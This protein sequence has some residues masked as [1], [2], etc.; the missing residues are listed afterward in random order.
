MTEQ[1]L[2]KTKTTKLT[3]R[4][5][6]TSLPNLRQICSVCP[7]ASAGTCSKAYIDQICK[8][9]EREALSEAKS[10]PRNCLSGL[11]GTVCLQHPSHIK[12]ALYVH[13][14]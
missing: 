8:K 11:E 5:I 4:A 2:A 10:S 6:S 9:D 1:L 7:L 14:Q 13:P 12:F 3:Q